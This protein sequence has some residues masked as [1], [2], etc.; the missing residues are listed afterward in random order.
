MT[1]EQRA[2][3]DAATA[4][5]ERQKGVVTEEQL[6]Q[7]GAAFDDQ[8]T[9][10][11]MA[12]VEQAAQEG[13]VTAEQEL[14]EVDTSGNQA[15][16][17]GEGQ[18]GGGD[19]ELETEML[20]SEEE[21]EGAEQENATEEQE[22]RWERQG[23]PTTATSALS[24]GVFTAEWLTSDPETVEGYVPRN[25]VTGWEGMEAK[26]KAGYIL[27]EIATKIGELDTALTTQLT[28]IELAAKGSA[29]A[30]EHKVVKLA[31]SMRNSELVF[32]VV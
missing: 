32:T 9:Q 4:E 8:K 30:K 23:L 26:E 2:Q 28:L 16:G 27:R 11:G 1:V 31:P 17:E 13:G 24:T 20:A 25:N 14:Q 18:G 3:M 15:H 5:Q 12:F 7:K 10:E 29:P 22:H 6:Q 19:G 21:G